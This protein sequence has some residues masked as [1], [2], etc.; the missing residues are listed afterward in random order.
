MKSTS[1]R[2]TLAAVS[3]LGIAGVG[4]GIG[5]AAMADPSSAS[6]SS[7]PSS[8]SSAT[9][10]TTKED[11][12][13]GGRNGEHGGGVGAPAKEL[14]AKLGLSESTVSQAIKDARES[15]AKPSTPSKDQTEAERE[16]ARTAR[17]KHFVTALAAKLK[18][19]EQ[20]LTTAIQAV[21]ADQNA[22]QT[23]ALT[24]KLD[25]A[26][27]AGTLTRAEADAVLKAA[28]AGVIDVHGR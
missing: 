6:P 21:Q 13:K 14:A 2:I 15:A 23:A 17:H 5:S 25:S 22:A 27:K 12:G 10:G 9:P 11:S 1:K 3:T 7:K 16:A 26:V 18:I 8:S 19:T 28:K 4:L 20:K 24:T